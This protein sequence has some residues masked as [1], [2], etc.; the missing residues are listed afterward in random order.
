M[1]LICSWGVTV[2][3]SVRQTDLEEKALVK[4]KTRA[5]LQPS[6]SMS[7]PEQNQHGKQGESMRFHSLCAGQITLT[8]LAGVL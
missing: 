3:H 8:Y 6:C 5:A 2:T 1:L 7:R 4:K